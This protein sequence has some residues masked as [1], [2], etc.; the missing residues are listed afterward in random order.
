MPRYRHLVVPTAGQPRSFTSTLKPHTVVNNPQRNRQNH[1]TTL[2]NQ[3][4]G[5][6][7][8]PLTRVARSDGSGFYQSPSLTITFESSPDFRLQFESLDLQQSGIEL[9]SVVTGDDHRTRATIRV[10]VGKVST[11]IKRLE[12]YRDSNPNAPIPAGKKRRPNDYAKLVESISLIKQA[13][14]RELWTDPEGDYPAANTPITWEVWLR[15]GDD[16]EPSSLSIL[17][18]AAADLGYVVASNALR[19]VDRT[20]VLV[21]G[22][23]EQLSLGAEVLGV[24]AEVRKA[25]IAASFFDRLKVAEQHGWIANLVGRLQPAAAGSPVVSLL[26]TG[27]NHAHPLLSPVIVPARDLHTHHPDWGVHD[28]GPHGTWMAGLALYGDLT[29]PL[30]AADP[31]ALIHGLESHKLIHQPNPHDPQL[32]GV[33][34]VEGINRLEGGVQRPRIYC[35]AITAL[36]SAKGRPSSW[37]AAIDALA[38]GAE[39]NVRRLILISAGNCDP[40]NHGQYPDSNEVSPIQD[41]AQSWNALTVGGYTDK[42]FI[43]LALSPGWTP[44]AGAGDLS[45]FSTTSVLWSSPFKAPYK[46]DVVMEAGNLGKSAPA[47]QPNELPELMMLSTNHEFA[48]GDRPF[49][50]MG[51]T[52]GATALAANLLAQLAARYPNF[53]PETLR[54]LLIHS[55][56]WT[57]PM[58]ARAT[59]PDGSLDGDRLLRLFGY[60]IPNA[61][62]LFTS[63]NNSLTLIAQDEVQPFFKDGKRGIKSNDMKVHALPWPAAVLQA[64]PL[65]TQVEMRVTLSYFIE[66][67]PGER[68][69]DRKY[70]YP[71]HGLRFKVKRAAE[72]LADFQARINSEDQDE[73]YVHDPVGETGV[74]VLGSGNPRR[75]SVHSNIWR[76]TAQDLANRAHI[77]VHPSIGWWKTRPR[78]NRYERMARYSLIVSITTPDQNTDIYTPVA[79]LINVP[80][81]IVT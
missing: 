64:L 3:I 77:I 2:L 1:G 60:G 35:M 52:S 41:P 32:Y 65:G 58:L 16:E 45:P 70:G 53:T 81:E 29:T 76:G 75:G 30:A 6:A 5:I 17:Q 21:R 43:D 73:D 69:W 67:S 74:W 79:N 59:R 36:D 54:G 8:T 80:V 15:E 27:I 56:R 11:L 50:T 44:V 39:D 51:E 34:T 40:A 78:E 72:T 37:S 63:A 33:V 12:K 20:V 10:P 61:D 48:A 55:A 9:L 42:A 25:K 38:S 28:T 46:P 71:S 66:P 31:V 18:E 14:L 24:I 13:T 23:R 19:F 68:G 49:T 4:R 7:N 62:E 26:D 47:A 57:A 22:T